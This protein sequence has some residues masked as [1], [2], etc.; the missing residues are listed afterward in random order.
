MSITGELKYQA[1]DTANRYPP[2]PVPVKLNCG[3]PL[4]LKRSPNAI[5]VAI[6]SSIESIFLEGDNHG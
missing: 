1:C 4:N 2:Q 3:F 6:R 5:Q